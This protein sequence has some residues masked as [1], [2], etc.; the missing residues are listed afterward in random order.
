MP[1]KAATTNPEREALS[2][3]QVTV[4]EAVFD[5]LRA[6]KL[7][8]VFG[9]PGSTEL[10]M[11]RNFPAEF[12]YILG[13]EESVA[14]AMADGYAQATREAALVNLHSATGVGHALGNIFTAFKN[15]T[16]LLI[17][18]G[19]QARSILPFEPFLYSAQA[20]EFP[21]PYVKWSCEPARAEDVPA[22]IARAYYTAMQSPRGPT[23]VS[24]PVDD[25]DRKCS[26]L[27]PRH[28]S[29]RVSGDPVELAAA[30]EAMSRAQRPVIV[31]GAGVAR[32]DAWGETIALAEWHQALVWASPMSSRN[33]FPENHP[34]FAGFLA[35]DRPKIVAS[36][37][38]ADFILVLGAPAFTYHVE[39]FGP[40]IPEGAQLVQLI[41][42]PAIAAWAP[43][44]TSIVT[45]LKLGVQALLEGSSPGPRTTAQLRVRPPRLARDRLT[46][47][48][49]L[50]QIAALRP[51]GAV[52]V[53]EAPSSRG[54]MHDHLPMIERDSFYTCASG[55]LGH[56]LPAAVGV[57]LARPGNRIIA[58]L[59]DGSSMYTIQGLWSA[60]QLGLAM[61]FIVINNR[62]Y[63]ALREFRHHF[64]LDRLPGTELPGLDFC[65]LAQ[66]QGVAA[67]RVD[68]IE[69]LDGALTTA[70]QSPKPILVE[71]VV[72]RAVDSGAGTT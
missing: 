47:R 10:P 33:S 35:A 23:F 20:T 49:L 68:R 55:G 51:A 60:A 59:G 70:F 34:L 8:T 12:R 38:G 13:L 50:Q 42:D 53:E 9:N 31:V 17:T 61:T 44:G 36:L 52:I 37:K 7:T 43:T 45:H 62:S 72:E 1:D 71:V 4:R 6:F 11:F 66:S 41:D 69:E 25:W 27:A 3:S 19:Q 30:A 48:Y 28:V 67:I 15:Q 22:A 46:D 63:E 56:G 29:Q 21:R 32:D 14:V 5:L 26:P 64:A 18:A 57:A 2:A 39:G 58:L 24:I 40:H 54:P 16:P 65:G